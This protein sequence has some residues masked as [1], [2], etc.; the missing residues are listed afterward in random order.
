VI[1]IAKDITPVDQ[2]IIGGVIA[3]GFGI[4]ALFSQI[5][6]I[7]WLWAVIVGYAA[8]GIA[9]GIYLMENSTAIHSWWKYLT[10]FI[11]SAI[12]Y[13]LTQVAQNFV[14]LNVHPIN[15]AIIAAFV[16]TLANFI[17]NDLQ[18]NYAKFLPDNV[19]SEITAVIGAIVVAAEAVQQAPA[20]SIINISTLLATIVPVLMAYVFQRIPWPTTTGTT[21]A[22][23][24]T[25]A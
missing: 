3:V 17:L 8:S 12:A 15:A 4:L 22:A 21:A 7:S 5:F 13:V 16:V 23:A 6:T 14:S 18:T 2:F 1:F 19:V 24:S 25:A 20:G 10:I 9:Y 11:V